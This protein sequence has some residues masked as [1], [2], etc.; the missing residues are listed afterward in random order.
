MFEKWYTS[1]RS[2]QVV[3]S[4]NF[5][6]F[7]ITNISETNMSNTQR[8]DRLQKTIFNLILHKTSAAGIEFCFG[9]VV[10]CSREY[11]I[12]SRMGGG[13]QNIY[14]N[15]RFACESCYTRRERFAYDVI[16]ICY[17]QRTRR[18]LRIVEPKF[19]LGKRT[20]KKICACKSSI[21][22]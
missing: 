18:I 9:C 13:N 20:A 15:T 21:S 4:H 3:Y 16:T 2:L 7:S 5:K 19:P 14:S 11:Y 22:F 17:I 8:T 1:L 10:C 6:S 12:S